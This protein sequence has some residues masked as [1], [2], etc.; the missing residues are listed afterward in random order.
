MNPG[1]VPLLPPSASTVSDELDMLF[2]YISAV[3]AFFAILILLL[4]VTFALRYRRRSR[5]QVVEQV[6]GNTP[7]ELLWTGVPLVLV[8]SFFFWGADL[9]FRIETPP[10]QP[11]E[12]FVVGK[13]WMWKI[14]HQEGPREINELHIPV[15]QAVQLTMTSEDVIHSFFVPAFRVKQDVLPG[16]YTRL[17][18][19]ATKT[20]VYHLFCAEYC[21]TEH[22]GM[23]GRVVVMEPAEYQRWLGGGTSG[24]SLA[25]AGERLFGQ[26]GCET[27]HGEQPGARGPSLRGVYGSLVRLRSGASV[28]V[29][30]AYIRESIVEPAAKVVAGY[31]VLMPTYQGQISEEGLMQLIAYIRSL[32]AAQPAAAAGEE[33]AR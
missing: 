19:E 10:A 17:W 8:L 29:D 15:N 11:L 30:E 7:L 3:S 6:Q 33:E 23:I 14:Q 20:G 32:A 26:L 12:I 1:N 21:G 31:D 4:V 22:A 13:Q 16:R 5:N 18:F 9:F 28:R 24:E 2:G 25:Q 27:C